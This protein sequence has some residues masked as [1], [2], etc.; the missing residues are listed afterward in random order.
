MAEFTANFT[1][2]Q[3]EAIESTFILEDGI[4]LD[5]V[6]VVHPTPDRLSQLSNDANYVQDTDYVHTDNNFTD[7]L[8]TNLNNQ[9]GVNTGDQ[10]LSS[11][12]LITD[13][14]TALSELTDDSTHRLSNEANA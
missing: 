5:A 8:L 11:Y 12:A 7:A 3:I 14:P 10:D 13:V 1:L 9:S 4:E 6:F 2:N